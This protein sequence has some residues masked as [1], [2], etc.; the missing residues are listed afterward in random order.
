MH[1]HVAIA[2]RLEFFAREQLV[3]GLGFLQ[4]QNVR[5]DSLTSRR[6][7][8]MRSRTELM[9]QVMT[10]SATAHPMCWAGDRNAN[11]AMGS[12]R[13]TD[14]TGRRKNGA[15]SGGRTGRLL[16]RSAWGKSGPAGET[17]PSKEGLAL[18]ASEL[19]KWGRVTGQNARITHAVSAKM[20]TRSG[21][22]CNSLSCAAPVADA[23][24]V[25]WQACAKAENNARENGFS[26]A[27]YSGCH[28]TPTTNRARA[29]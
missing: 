15:R 13:T 17:G 2:E 20:H 28:C 12:Q 18:S 7:S 29:G 8:S 24:L 10:R 11:G 5:A 16:V 19:M 9:F 25:A 26:R 23:R 4:A 3:R 1:Q 22:I 6:T 14:A 27:L 21:T